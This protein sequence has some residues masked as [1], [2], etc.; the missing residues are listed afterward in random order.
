M[1]ATQLWTQ[2][3]I[4]P[5][6]GIRPQHKALRPVVARSPFLLSASAQGMVRT[7][8]ADSRYESRELA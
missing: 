3:F 1:H 6:T 7:G 2:L 4:G 8:A 5:L